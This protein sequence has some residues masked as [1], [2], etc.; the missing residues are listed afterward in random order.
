MFLKASCCCA[1][2]IIKGFLHRV[3]PSR[4]NCS[5]MCCSEAVGSFSGALNVNETLIAAVRVVLGKV[6]IRLQSRAG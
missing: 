1:S 6:S 4:V 2:N 3:S 5:E